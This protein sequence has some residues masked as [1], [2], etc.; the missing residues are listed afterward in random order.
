MSI[1]PALYI[2][3]KHDKHKP[4]EL[5]SYFTE[6]YNGR[7]VGPEGIFAHSHAAILT[8]EEAQHRVARFPG[9]VM[10]RVG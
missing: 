7:Y 10:L 8:Y 9:S 4:W 1:T 6:Y 2:V 3:R 5:P